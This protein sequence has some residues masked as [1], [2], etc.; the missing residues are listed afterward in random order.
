MKKLAIKRKMLYSLLIPYILLG[1]V[2]T[3][4]FGYMYITS[5]KNINNESTQSNYSILNKI[6]REVDY[7]ISDVERL[8]LEIES[9]YKFK[10]ILDVV[11]GNRSGT[12]NYE[13]AMALQ[14]LKGIK[15]YNHLIE[16]IIIYYQKGDFFINSQ[17]IRSE[18]GIYEDY[19]DNIVIPYEEWKGTLTRRYEE[20]QL[21][22][23]GDFIYYGITIPFNEIEEV[24]NIIIKVN[25]SNLEELING[26]STLNEGSLYIVDAQYKGILKNNNKDIILSGKEEEYFQ[27]LMQSQQSYTGE[28]NINHKKHIMLY[29]KGQNLELQYIWLIESNKLKQKSNY[30]LI[31][32]SSMGIVFAVLFILGIYGVKSNYQKIIQIIERLSKSNLPVTEKVQSEVSYIHSVL[33]TMEQ[34]IEEQEKVMIE[35][36]IRKALYGLIEDKDEEYTELLTTHKNLCE[37]QSIVALFEDMKCS[38]KEAKEIKLNIFIIENIIKELFGSKIISWIVPINNWHV[39]IINWPTGEEYEL[40]YILDSLES[41]RKFLLDQLELSYTIGISSPS[42]GISQLAV[43]YKEAIQALEEKQV[44][45][46]NR[47]IY[48]GDIVE[49]HNRYEYDESMS[50]QL[51]NYIKL[52]DDEKAKEFIEAIYT[53]NFEQNHISVEYGKLLILELIETIKEVA[54]QL[55]CDISIEPTEVLKEIYTAYDMKNTINEAISKLCKEGLQSRENTESR[56]SKILKYIQEN[57]NDSNLN[58]AMIADQFELNPSYLSRFFK[59]QTGENL[60]SYINN[61]RVERAKELL[62]NTDKTLVNISLEIGFVNAAALTRA[63]KKYEGITPGQYKAIHKKENA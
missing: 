14:E 55:K 32:F 56:E 1:V 6:T 23:T 41:V 22:R 54:R 21:A 60:L 5:V 48:Y 4:F 62:V 47:I 46:N 2:G 36:T 13:I 57:Y 37:G 30:I 3:M 18:Q 24:A 28:I 31:A 33:N 63:F 44:M 58:V 59:E 9:N 39:M 19:K 11:K 15:R 10:R 29:S 17:S 25:T 45:G 38:D 40:E 42:E 16:D 49:H 35:N 52:G 51:I 26:Y 50:K 7:L 8:V 34:R 27:Q 53:L 43:A 61:Y 12:D 20:G